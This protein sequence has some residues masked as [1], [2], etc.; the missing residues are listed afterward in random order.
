MFICT[1]PMQVR[2]YRFFFIGKVKK[3]NTSLFDFLYLQI[4]CLDCQ[5]TCCIISSSEFETVALHQNHA[6]LSCFDQIKSYH[7][8]GQFRKS[9]KIP[10]GDGSINL[11]DIYE[12]QL[13][14]VC[15]YSISIQ[16]T[17]INQCY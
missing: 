9:H 7:Y 3:K 10:I 5:I 2:R 12:N 14:V 16:S 11:L 6:I 1:K 15:P 8:T 4:S 17:L 13:I